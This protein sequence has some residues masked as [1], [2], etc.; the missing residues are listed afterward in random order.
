MDM[1]KYFLWEYQGSHT[2]WKIM[3]VLEKC[4]FHP[5]SDEVGASRVGVKYNYNYDFLNIVNYNYDL[6][7]KSIIIKLFVHKKVNYNY[8]HQ[9]Q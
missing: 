8:F 2:S 1:L 6:R 7:K 3:A 4:Y 5:P 9:L